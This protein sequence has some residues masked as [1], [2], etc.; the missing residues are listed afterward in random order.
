[1]DSWHNGAAMIVEESENGR[2]YKCND[3]HPDENFD[4]IIFHVQVADFTDTV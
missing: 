4:D 2:F 3:G 1:M